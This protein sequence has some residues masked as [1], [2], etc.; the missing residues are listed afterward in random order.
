MVPGAEDSIMNMGLNSPVGE[1]MG[2]VNE[3]LLR[4]D[5]LRDETMTK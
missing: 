3:Y 2:R 5:E 1:T 4:G